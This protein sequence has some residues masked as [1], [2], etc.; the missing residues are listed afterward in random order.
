M[1]CGK[2]EK[3]KFCFPEKHTLM[4]IIAATLFLFFIGTVG[5]AHDFELN[6]EGRTSPVIKKTTLENV[7]QVSDIVPNFWK[8]I[9]LPADYRSAFSNVLSTCQQN[10]CLSLIDIHSVEIS[11]FCN[12]VRTVEKG[13]NLDI[14]SNQ[15]EMLKRADMGMVINIFISFTP[16]ESVGM[17]GDD[18]MITGVIG[19]KVV[20]A[21]EAKYPGGFGALSSYLNKEMVRKMKFEDIPDYVNF[22]VDEEGQVN[23]V[24]VM[25]LQGDQVSTIDLFIE[26]VFL[27]M[28]NWYPAQTISGDHVK[29]EFTIPFLGKGC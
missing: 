25:R 12:G 13:K 3:G 9:H 24:N 21:V 16:K 29:Q 10:E 1:I 23:D 19:T 8:K 6:Y 14:T 7:E 4:R 22:M 17:S 15:K 26:E 18:K 5:M 28:P 20:S 11:A 27:K 2:F